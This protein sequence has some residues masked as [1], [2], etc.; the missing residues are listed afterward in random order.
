MR[1][2]FQ[3]RLDG[4]KIAAAEQTF[5]RFGLADI[6]REHY[7]PAAGPGVV[8]TL[9]SGAKNIAEL[10]RDVFLGSPVTFTETLKRYRDTSKSYPH[11]LARYIKDAYMSPGTSRAQ[12]AFSLG[13][14]LYF[15]G[16]GLLGAKENR[17]EQLASGLVGAVTYPVLGRFGEAGTKVQAGI[18]Q[19]TEGLVRHL[20]GKSAPTSPDSQSSDR[21]SD[22]AEIA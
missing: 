21:D 10:G 19:A 6:F 5:K 17:P 7:V 13:L 2:R 14:P 9:A 8:D 3:E 11:A 16:S 4:V 20:R 22:L 12:K 15:L 1:S 18:G